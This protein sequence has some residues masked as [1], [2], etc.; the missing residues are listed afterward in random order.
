MVY[1]GF[2][3]S[4]YVFLRDAISGIQ[5]MSTFELRKN[6]LKSSAHHD[7]LL[8]VHQIHQLSEINVVLP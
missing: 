1:D 5:I 3:V 6:Y 4:S 8:L 7:Y 2:Q